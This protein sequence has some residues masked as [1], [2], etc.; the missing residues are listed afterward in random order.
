MSRTARLLPTL[1]AGLVLALALN[2]PTSLADLGRIGTW[3]V[4]LELVTALALCALLPRPRRLLAARLLAAPLALLIAF[5]LVDWAVWRMMGRPVTLVFDVPLAGSLIALSRDSFGLPATVLLL[6]TAALTVLL[7]YVLT[8]RFLSGLAG[9]GVAR[10]A[11]LAVTLAAGSMALAGMAT[12]APGR[13][14]GLPL[15]SLHGF[16]QVAAQLERAADAADAA[17]RWRQTAEA[18]PAEAIPPDLLLGR[19]D[20]VDVLVLF[21]ES[22]GRT[23][24]EQPAFAGTI[25]PRLATWERALDAH[26]LSAASGWLI[27]PTVGGQSWLAHATLASG[28]RTAD[29]AS[30][31]VYLERASADLAHLFARSGHRSVLAVP[32][33]TEAWP[34]LGRLG[35]ETVYAAPDLGYRGPGFDWVTM[36]DQYTLATLEALERG[37]SMERRPLF[38]QAALIGSHAPFTPIPPLVEDW[39]L[40]GD[41][42]LFAGLPRHGGEAREVWRDPASLKRHYLG[43]LDLVLAT[44]QA[45]STRFVDRRTLLVVL[46]DHEPAPLVSGAPDERRVPVHVVSGDPGLLAPFRAWGL[47][48]GTT[49]GAD[50]AVHPMEA[51]RGF[52]LEAFSGRSE[53]EAS[54]PAPGRGRGNGA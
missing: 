45:Y 21:V 26:G 11:A 48:A 2:L 29:Q 12:P 54:A 43:A 53:Q 35:F 18:D 16:Y 19:L 20:G 34:E 37:Q 14:V 13:Q 8:A 49:P 22:Y 30:F 31:R 44:I 52:L 23:A 25:R 33:I 46:G 32:A 6:L 42:S 41:G 3:A 40:I 15:V 4:P 36:P 17:R 1:A 39:T 27:S 5:R 38:L 28:I 9:L 50:A 7:L 10:P 51:F 47:T 24:L